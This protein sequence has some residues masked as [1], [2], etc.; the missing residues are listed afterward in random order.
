MEHSP[1]IP[2]FGRSTEF[3]VHMVHLKLMPNDVF[4]K[5]LD[6]RIANF[7]LWKINSQLDFMEMHFSS[8]REHMFT[9]AQFVLSLCM[10]NL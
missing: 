5:G 6:F 4:R 10:F 3:P 9:E 2:N 7:V 1:N 8:F